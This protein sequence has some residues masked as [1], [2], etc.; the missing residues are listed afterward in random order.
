[1]KDCLFCK[2]VKKEIPAS[3]VYEDSKYIAFLDIMPVNKGHTLVIPKEHHEDLLS[4]S[5]SILDGMLN[6]AKKIAKG[7]LSAVGSSGCNV[8]FNVGPVAGQVVPHLHLHIMPRFED[9]GYSL[10]H[11]K[12]YKEGEMQDVASKIRENL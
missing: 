11:G 7:V 2:I 4:T 6:I 12:E 5:D 8:S 1:M 10:W 3:I 9:D